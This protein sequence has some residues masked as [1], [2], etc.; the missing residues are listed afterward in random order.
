MRIDLTCEGTDLAVLGDRGGSLGDVL[1]L[2]GGEHGGRAH[3]LRLGVDVRTGARLPQPDRE[4]PVGLE[5]RVVGGPDG[6]RRAALGRGPVIIGRN[7]GAGADLLVVDDA[8]LSRRHARIEPTGHR[9]RVVDL[10]STNC[11]QLDGA[12][13]TEATLDP[14]GLLALGDT[15]VTVERA[16][17]VP[18]AVDWR[19]DGTGV[20]NRPPP[21]PSPPAPEPVDPIAEPQPQP[22]GRIAW[23][24]ALLPAL[25]GVGMA[26]RLH[27]PQFLLFMVAS[28]L[29]LL[30]SSAGERM[31]LRRRR[32]SELRA[33]R[34]DRARQDRLIADRLAEEAI[35]RRRRLPDPT[36]L[37]DIAGLPAGRLWESTPERGLVVRAGLASLDSEL[38]VRA[39]PDTA[40]AGRVHDVPAVVDLAAGLGLC[41]PTGTR[42]AMARW[43][44]CQLATRFSPAD[45]D[46]AVVVDSGREADWTWARWLPHV[47]GTGWVAR[48]P[49]Q[50]RTLAI[51]LESLIASRNDALGP[52]ASSWTGRRL[53][54][55]VD[56]ADGVAGL[57]PLA[58]ALAGASAV[59]VSALWLA[60]AAS[61]LPAW[62]EQSL[63]VVGDTGARAVLTAAGRTVESVLLDAVPERYADDLA[64]RLAPLVDAAD[65]GASNRWRPARLLDLLGLREIDPDQ[66][67]RRWAR[68]D[69][70]AA[71]DI[72]TAPDGPVRLDLLRDGPH[73]LIA[74]T[75]GSGKSE[76][77]QSLVAGLSA[78]YPPDQVSFVL[79]DYK[80]GAAFGACARLPHVSGLVTDLDHHL[81]RRALRS[82]EAEL[83][84]R[85][86][87][88]AESGTTDLAG[89]RAAVADHAEA[90]PVPRLVIVVDEFAALAEE[91]PDFITGLVGVAQRGRSL[92]V[93][94]VLAT[95]RP[96]GVVSP[97]IR[98]N[99]ALRIALRVTDAGESTEVIGTADAAH[100]TRHQP[101]RGYVARDG[102]LTQ[103]QVAR[104]GVP[105]R[106]HSDSDRLRVVPLGPWRTL[107]GGAEDTADKTDLDLLC[108]AVGE[109]WRLS[110]RRAAAA[111]WLAP[112][113][114][115]VRT[116]DLPA[117]G[118]AARWC[119]GWSICPTGSAAVRTNCPWTAAA[120]SWPARVAPGGAPCCCRSRSPPR[121]RTRRPRST[122]SR[123][124]PVRSRTCWICRGA[125]RSR[126]T[127]HR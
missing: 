12:E 96:G 1:P 79:I 99:T 117:V 95:Q 115:V 120:Y 102:Q 101:G 58:S 17:Q 54:V 43:M 70:G 77:L 114:A 35:T 52:T 75:T 92:G 72:G 42:Q 33:Y 119:S 6:G 97:E 109:A 63:R 15:R 90:Q 108:D 31:S 4:E 112:L 57:A 88:L 80:G 125:G 98:A 74:G 19:P 45:V 56:V 118:P 65:R 87:L 89:Y 50:W 30:G 7:P 121:V 84:R 85:E 107:P 10:G 68:S 9:V 20:V 2:V 83:T 32:R 124:R 21:L 116:D 23:M 76:L 34:R 105:A 37:A 73:T 103:V 126:G 18:A 47:H 59:G 51:E 8:S 26:W 86:R 123:P 69:S 61:D 94:L 11:T 53:V 48:D 3:A 29:M 66:V 22:P 44:V 40:P 14:G 100:I 41:A 60:P 71:T 55:V 25:F 67:R 111:P 38:G 24:A 62:C 36:V 106:L 5:V 104:I 27:N 46:I 93:H 64:R 113:P 39:G 82:L 122:R 127:R 28:P 110:G 49:D 16:G 78:G 81:T 13:V 91:L